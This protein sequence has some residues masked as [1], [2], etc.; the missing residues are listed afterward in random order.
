MHF[1]DIIVDISIKNLDKT[2]Q[3]IVPARLEGQLLAG[4]PVWIPFGKGNKK[5][6][7]TVMGISEVPLLPLSKMK[8][9]IGIVEGAIPV[10]E[11]MLTLAYWIRETYGCTMNEAIRTVLPVR[12]SIKEKQSRNVTK[13]ISR[14]KIKEYYEEAQK[15][16]YSA[17]ERLLSCLL[18]KEEWDYSV[19]LS[20]SR[21][22]P[23]VIKVL[24]EKQVIRVE[25]K[26]LYRN[27]MEYFFHDKDGDFK[28]ASSDT[29]SKADKGRPA[30]M[31]N[32]EQRTAVDT[33]LSDISEGKS[34][35]Y[36]LH[37]ITGSGKTEVYMEII[38]RVILT[39]QVIM[40]IP[41]ISL[42]YQTVRRFYER[43]GDRV[44]FLHS[45]LSKGERSDQ[46]ER[47]KNGEIDIMI[48]PR[49]ALFTPF[50][51]LGLIIVDEEQENS[52]KSENSPRYH[53]RETA[54]KRAAMLKIP[55][56]FGSATPA[57]DT[58]KKAAEGSYKLLTLNK[59][60][61]GQT[62]PDIYVADMREELKNKNYS[63]FSRVLKE[64]IEECL[65]NKQQAM[66]FINRR[67]YAGMVSCR[68]C[69][70]VIKCP[71]CDISLS[72]HRI[73]PDKGNIE[74]AGESAGVLKCHYCGNEI[75][76]VN[77]CPECN[78]A[79]IGTFGVGTQKLEEM[80][81][82]T[83]PGAR[84]LRMD[85]D[86]TKG[87]NGHQDILSEF[88]R[89]MADI[90]VGTQM[91][92]KGHDFPNVTLMGIMAAD[93]SLFAGSYK[94]GE[95]TYD[96]LVQAAGRSGRGKSPGN[97]VIQTYRP[98][99]YC[100]N[101]AVNSDYESFFRQEMA[102]RSICKYPPVYHMLA[103]LVF[104]AD[105]EAAKSMAESLKKRT[106]TYLAENTVE[107]INILGPV[108]AGVKKI[109]DVYRY[110]VYLKC[111]REDILINIK[112]MMEGR[113]ETADK[114]NVSVQFDY[115]PVHSY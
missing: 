10:Q 61:A 24:E 107:D 20:K 13:L 111:K 80:T 108:P 12:D 30:L 62:L 105:E 7:G 35:T 8:E 71:H 27:P 92:V 70:A 66:L 42:T 51:K 43:F 95:Q 36:L 3:Y 21:C 101:A 58:Y 64:K 32:D 22:S 115:D 75:P 63:V 112:R 89:G 26:R 31:L 41:E 57:V 38:S 109:N 39:R 49:S 72:Y 11:Q 65:E 104:S 73:S 9:I 16:H 18:D 98:D 96:L 90:L 74:Y 113:L 17:R 55:L 97:V 76:M 93:L 56:I 52:Y 110:I 81:K 100:I 78:S 28:E 44:S 19:L 59:R 37:G 54:V 23:Q 14:E 34:E 60:A 88:S 114:G 94:S 103:V 91:I 40:L 47:A 6:R 86:T 99:H 1:A 85:M 15:K 50:E 102:Y 48:G 67:G 84:V 106:D 33:V 83:F 46:Y 68:S 29:E 82:K 69:G 2:Y 5:I 77:K 4:T 25:S 45:R 79:Y 87:K 53:A